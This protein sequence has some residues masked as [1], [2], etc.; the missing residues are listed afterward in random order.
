VTGSRPFLAA[1]VLLGLFYGMAL[2]FAELEVHTDEYPRYL[3]WKAGRSKRARGYWY[4]RFSYRLTRYLS[5]TFRSSR[6]RL[7]ARLHFLRTSESIQLDSASRPEPPGFR[8]LIRAFRLRNDEIFLL[9]KE[10]KRDDLWTVEVKRLEKR[11]K[12]SET[13]DAGYLRYLADV[14]ESFS[15]SE[16]ALFS[17]VGPE[18]MSD[19]LERYPIRS[20]FVLRLIEVLGGAVVLVLSYLVLRR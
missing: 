6:R 5:W 16:R 3:A 7:L 11:I 12:E 2:Y 8:D 4:A 15:D 17:E 14:Y 1:G 13:L 18:T 19:W 9:S 20:Q 10:E